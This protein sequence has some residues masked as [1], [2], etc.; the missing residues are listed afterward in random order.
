MSLSFGTLKRTLKKAYTFLLLS[1]LVGMTLS[2][3]AFFYVQDWERELAYKNLEE[4]LD[5][6]V[7]DLRQA[8][9]TFDSLLESVSGLHDVLGHIDQ[10]A[11]AKFISSKPLNYYGI[12]ALEWVTYIPP[13]D[14]R[15]ASQGESIWMLSPTGNKQ[16]LTNQKQAY[17]PITSTEPMPK[18]GQNIGYDVGSDP[19]LR[20]ALE[21]ARDQ[22]Q[23]VVS[24][25][26][27]ILTVTGT[28]RDGVR[29]FFP[30]Y[31]PHTNPSTVAERRQSLAG[32][33][34]VMFLVD[35]MIEAVVRPRRSLKKDIF[36]CIFDKTSTTRVTGIYVPTWYSEIQ[37]INMV[38]V[39]VVLGGREWNIVFAKAPE[40]SIVKTYY[41][42]F[43]LSIGLLFTVGLWRYLHV[44]LSSAQWAEQLA[45]KRTHSLS[46]VNK[47]LNKEIT[48]REQITKA[49][50]VSQ[51]R[52][53]AIFDEAA[54][55]IVQTDLNGRILDCNRALQELLGYTES[56]LMGCFLN[57]FSHPQDTGADQEQ[58]VEMI[59]NIRDTFA[60]S[61]R[62]RCKGGVTVWTNQNCS[63][64]R[65]A[66]PPFII[67]I[68][69]DVTERKCAE[70]ARL[71]A[72]KKYRDIFEN[73]VEGIFQCTPTGYFLSV[74]PAFV[75]IFGYDSAE[76]MLTE[77]SNMGKQLYI[78]A[79]RRAEFIGLLQ[80]HAKVQDFEYEARCRDG[81]TIWVNETVRIVRDEQGQIRYYEGIIEDITQRKRA[82]EKLRYD[83]THD[84]LSGLLNRNAFTDY[85][86]TVLDN[87]HA[88]LNNEQSM[89][90]IDFAVLFVDLDRFKIVND[91]M[92]HLTGDKMLVEVGRRL[93][94]STRPQDLV[95]RFG[96]DEFAL[97][98]E[99]IP[100]MPILE[101]YVAQLQ[102]NLNQT[103]FIENETFNTSA[104]IGIALALPHYTT[105]N[106]VLRDADTAMYEAKRRG[107]N[108]AV[109]FQPG[110]HT[111][112]MNILRLESDLRKAIDNEEFS[113]YY[114]PIISLT[115][116]DPVGLEALIRWIHPERGMI[117]PDQFIPVAEETGLIV[118]IGLWVFETACRQLRC[119]Q[120][121]FPNYKDL[122]MNINVSP[123]QLKQPHLVQQIHSILQKTGIKAQTCRMEITEGAMMH[124]PE[125]ALRILRE[126]KELEI[127]LYV[128]DFGTGYS[129]LSYLQKFPLDAL[130]ID[131]SFIRD[132]DAS[133]KS[134]HV[135]R[136]IIALGEAFN[137]KVVA[138][139]VENDYQVTVLKTT[140][141]HHVQGYFFSRPKDTTAIEHYL[142]ESQIEYLEEINP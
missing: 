8:F 129:S 71:E 120:D 47:T 59:Q 24:E 13:T 92:G 72:E 19:L 45:A 87:Y 37:A 102:A 22:G 26:T 62:Y 35:E 116:N 74:N 122:G 3:L 125:A 128:D 127:L 98:I 131:K 79:Q 141:C 1:G 88:T 142:K 119:W 31:R 93:C 108:K 101:Q 138:E 99:N 73:A 80:T 124:D 42:W 11:L 48:R 54:M 15:S 114:Q 21:K 112:I 44:L 65:D 36:L 76:Q 111:H 40:V 2:L 30:V 113:L 25:V 84:Q 83:A 46:V 18:N 86:S 38:E 96:G 12:H 81:R 78:D 139:G 110:M 126:L 7:R 67:S 23:S 55:G 34:T 100:D 52:F 33:A 121:Q 140:H 85:L 16:A 14:Q 39:P 64:V 56:E 118:E 109:V 58:L 27:D 66:K 51:Q 82:E 28:I 10:T 29:V 106:E 63:I 132:I 70:Q 123:V 89:Q 57:D 130:K 134:M 49:L 105:A 135:T 103:Y 97:M 20:V 50:E 75:R 137:L 69:E 43:V 41:A 91:S 6:H 94:K 107:R 9:T 95:A 77:V 136:A 117:S 61:K 60:I 5:N 53:Q 133:G 4:R 17:Y 104:S 115:K 32:F 68:I 90:S